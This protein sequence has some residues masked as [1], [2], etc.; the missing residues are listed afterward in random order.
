MSDVSNVVLDS[1]LENLK[2]SGELKWYVFCAF[3]ELKR[4]DVSNMIPAFPYSRHKKEKKSLLLLLS[5]A[6]N[7]VG[8]FELLA[9]KNPTYISLRK[10]V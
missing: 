7:L 2:K 3:S 6:F 10:E 8:H 9:L 5:F 1:S 4:S